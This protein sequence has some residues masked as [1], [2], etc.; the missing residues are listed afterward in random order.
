MFIYPCEPERDYIKR[1][2]ATAGDTVE[3]RCNVVYVNGEAV[4][5]KLVVPLTTV[6]RPRRATT[7]R[8]GTRDRSASTE[9]TVNGKSYDTYHDPV[10]VERER[11]LAQGMLTDGASRDFPARDHALPPTCANVQD[12]GEEHRASR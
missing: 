11:L 4:P 9:E 3:V 8:S 2:V 5:S 12:G 7:I 6:R 10:R 1:V